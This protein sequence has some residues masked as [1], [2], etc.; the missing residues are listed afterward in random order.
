[1]RIGRR[2]KVSDTP[3]L[4]KLGIS[5]DQSSQWQK[6]A[7]IPEEEFERLLK[8]GS[9]PHSTPSTQGIIDAATKRRGQLCEWTVADAEARLKTAVKKELDRAP[10]HEVS[11]IV[12]LL[13]A[14]AS[15]IEGRDAT[16]GQYGEDR[17]GANS[18]TENVSLDLSRLKRERPDLFAWLDSF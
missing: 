4:S 13:R 18:K 7:A 17:V 3:T 12:F 2:P 1:M 14:I 16:T 6:L 10:A 9:G 15:E 11:R 5:R 8:A